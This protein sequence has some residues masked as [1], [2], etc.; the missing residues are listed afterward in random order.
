MRPGQW[1]RGPSR[2]QR[3]DDVNW[4]NW[5]GWTGW[6]GWSRRRSSRDVCGRIDPLAEVRRTSLDGEHACT[7][8]IRS[9]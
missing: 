7:V 2:S 3:W 8:T 9:T 4:T 5:T 1:T 6:T